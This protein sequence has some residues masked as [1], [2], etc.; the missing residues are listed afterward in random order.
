MLRL[1]DIDKFTHGTNDNPKG[2]RYIELPSDWLT[3]DV[4]AQESWKQEQ[5]DTIRGPRVCEI[6][7]ITKIDYSDE[8]RRLGAASSQKR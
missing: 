5:L 8:R 4:P 3:R 6:V 7:D 1:I 2:I